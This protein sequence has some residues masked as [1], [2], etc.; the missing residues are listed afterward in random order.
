MLFSENGINI[1]EIGKEASFYLNNL[2]EFNNV[3]KLFNKFASILIKSQIFNIY[4][5][6][7]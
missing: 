5:K 7:L 6:H 1:P 2:T 3:L 4:Y